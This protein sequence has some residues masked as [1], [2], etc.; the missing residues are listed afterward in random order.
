MEYMK[1]IEE[2]IG[3]SFLAITYTK[4]NAVPTLPEI[5]EDYAVVTEAQA[6]IALATTEEAPVFF[7]VKG[8]LIG[9]C[10]V[11]LEKATSLYIKEK[12]HA[13]IVSYNLDP[14]TIEVYVGPCL[15][16]SHQIVDRPLIEKMM[17]LGY[18]AAC[19]RTDGVDF[20]DI[21]VMIL[22]QLRELGVPMKNIHISDYDTYENPEIL[23]SK[24]RQ[25]GEKKNV[26]VATLL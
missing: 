10:P 13:S 15:T 1:N 11:T 4:G 23:Y 2:K 17:A 3:E 6:S 19:K 26:T 7:A 5:V 14:K 21:P 16:F 22:L 20:F 24:L 25:D 18:R 8:H 9:A 12:M